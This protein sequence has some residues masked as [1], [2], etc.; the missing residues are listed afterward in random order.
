MPSP[1][2]PQ[3][4]SMDLG[5]PISYLP[6]ELL[7][8]IFEL[9]CSYQ[10]REEQAFT[11][12]EACQFL[13][14]T[15]GVISEVCR[16]WRAVVVDTASLWSRILWRSKAVDYGGLNFD[17]T[18][19]APLNLVFKD[20]LFEILRLE[21]ERSK[22][23]LLK[24]D[25]R[26]A[27]RRIP[28]EDIISQFTAHLDRCRSLHIG[29]SGKAPLSHNAAEPLLLSNL[30]T[31]SIQQV[32][33]HVGDD[34]DNTFDLRMAPRLRH[35]Y[36]ERNLSGP[37]FHV[38]LPPRCMLSSLVLYNIE[39]SVAVDVLQGCSDVETLYFCVGY[40][41]AHVKG[42]FHLP[43][44]RSLL[45]QDSIPYLLQDLDAP[46]LDTLVIFE[47]TSG[48]PL[49]PFN[50][51]RYLDVVFFSP[52]RVFEDAGIM[53][54]LFS[55]HRL[56]ELHLSIAMCSN[57]LMAWLGSV[58]SWVS[59]PRWRILRVTVYS[60]DGEI[61]MAMSWITAMLHNR[62][63]LRP[64]LMEDAP[65]LAVH[66]VGV[67][68]A[69]QTVRDWLERMGDSTSITEGNWLLPELDLVNPTMTIE[70]WH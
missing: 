44:L 8:V 24:L 57:M 19:S 17:D 43:S 7:S 51:L 48:I 49:R 66:L 36:L 9:A 56:E 10:A 70:D 40:K 41:P 15:R 53:N 32:T 42:R 69:E 60:G 67:G 63:R 61:D 62:S 59:W 29:F 39:P 18:D 37:Q 50:Q 27:N 14:T 47:L 46:N 26:L 6:P 2:T 23:H 5:P 30:R 3:Q 58:E 13:G 25:W 34:E 21:L 16:R 68:A 38:R 54:D 33:L 45:L 4:Q 11:T 65:T 55:L 1:P 20:P 52:T 22:N 12:E 31:L 64:E 28:P 35:L